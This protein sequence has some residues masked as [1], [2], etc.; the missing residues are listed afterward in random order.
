MWSSLNSFRVSSSTNSSGGY[1]YSFIGNVPDRL[2]CL[3]CQKVMRDPTLVV[4]CGKKFCKSCL[5]AFLNTQSRPSCP[6]C[7]ATE[8]ELFKFLYVDEKGLKYEIDLLHIECPHHKKGCDWTGEIRNLGKHFDPK[9]NH[10]QLFDSK[11]NHLQ[12]F[13]KVCAFVEIT[14]SNCWIWKGEYRCYKE[15]LKSDN[16]CPNYLVYCPN[17][18]HDGKTQV[19]RK[20]LSKHLNS[21]CVLRDI[22]CKHCHALTWSASTSHEAICP[23]LPMECPN[24]CGEKGLIRETIEAHHQTCKYELT[25]CEYAHIWLQ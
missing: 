15:H 10:F 19:L 17:K 20:N 23:K 8:N 14:C 18:C 7:Q 21:R 12:Q 6:N 2:L 25:S 5:Q 3:I 13:H 4:C 11:L 22:A 16:G 9:L 1:D 24:N